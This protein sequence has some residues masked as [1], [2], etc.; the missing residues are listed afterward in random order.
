MHKVTVV[1][2]L[3]NGSP[4][5]EIHKDMN[6]ADALVFLQMF[7]SNAEA[8]VN[9]ATLDKPYVVKVTRQ[10]YGWIDNGLPGYEEAAKKRAIQKMAV[11]LRKEA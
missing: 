5:T 4:E 1:N 6:M 2:F 9:A 10:S 8:K 7:T 3:P 11:S